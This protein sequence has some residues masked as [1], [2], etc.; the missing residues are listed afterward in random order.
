M[1]TNP[2]TTGLEQMMANS[3]TAGA[4]NMAA[5]LSKFSAAR[6]KQRTQVAGNGVG[7]PADDRRERHDRHRINA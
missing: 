7:C 5:M 6:S 4:H 3:S 1:V 2:S